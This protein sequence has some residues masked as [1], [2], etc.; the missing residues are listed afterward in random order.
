M[1][2]L[3]NGL[4]RSGRGDATDRLWRS[5]GSFVK[6]GLLA[7]MLG[8]AHAHSAHVAP[9]VPELP[10]TCSGPP[11]VPSNEYGV[12]QRDPGVHDRPIAHLALVGAPEAS[13]A[14]ILAAL[15]AKVGEHLSDDVIDDDVRMLHDLA[16][17]ERVLATVHVDQDGVAVE[18]RLEPRTAIRRVT[19][20]GNDPV[21][22]ELAQLEGA[23]D[24]RSRLARMRDHAIERWHREGYLDATIEITDDAGDVCIRASAGPRYTIERLE[25]TGASVL[26]S[27][28]IARRFARRSGSV[29]APGGILD[30]RLFAASGDALARAYGDRGYAAMSYEPT[31]DTD[32]KRAHVVI[33]V[34]IHEGAR[35]RFGAL[36]IPWPEARAMVAAA[37]VVPGRTFSL[38][39]VERAHARVARWGQPYGFHVT[40][41]TALRPPNAVDVTFEPWEVVH[42]AP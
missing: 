6:A 30:R 19:V 35:Y 25:V 40:P 17:A 23:L 20:Y 13:R 15:H 22:G 27:D 37:G 16:V 32:R 21:L 34:A 18:Y 8:C 29:N 2:S 12:I 36:A 28:E 9:P 24:D 4:T 3:G 31:F 7:A 26:P 1:V 10:A 5:S 39:A 42:D 14:A 33:H 41:V 38:L 11:V